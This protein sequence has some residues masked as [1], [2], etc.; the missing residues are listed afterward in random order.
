[1]ATV[2]Q[3]GCD[4]CDREFTAAE[5]Y[6]VEMPDGETAVCCPDC[7]SHAKDAAE[8]QAE[9]VATQSCEGCGG[10]FVESELSA[11]LLPDGVTVSLC[12]ACEAESPDPTVD[13]G[14]GETREES[15]GDEEVRNRCDQ[16]R[17]WVSAELWEVVTVDDR[18]E[19][20]CQTC[21]NEAIDEGVVQK[22]HLRCAEAREILD[23]EPDADR[24]VIRKSYLAQVKR[25]HPD[26]DTGSTLAFKRVQ[27][28][29]DRLVDES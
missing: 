3:N 11:V 14:S 16:C 15:H 27:R 20:F 24:T 29:Y 9:L 2:D 4:G 1:M 28:A 17:E 21:K 18:V 10:A 12:D 26:R 5:L 8:K 6:P 19:E 23:V 13:A 22:V 25:A 7:R